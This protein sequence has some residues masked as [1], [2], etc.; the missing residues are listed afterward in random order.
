VKYL[1]P[2]DRPHIISSLSVKPLPNIESGAFKRGETPLLI[3]S[4]FQIKYSTVMKDDPFE[5][6]IKGVSIISSPK[7][8][9]DI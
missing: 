5:R 4:P 8:A 9:R 6:G 7:P 3:I 1:F 2:P